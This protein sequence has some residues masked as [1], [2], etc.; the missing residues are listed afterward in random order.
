MARDVADS[1]SKLE[2]EFHRKIQLICLLQ[3]HPIRLKSI[4]D[5]SLGKLVIAVE[6]GS[7]EFGIGGEIAALLGEN[8]RSPKVFVRVAAE[9]FPVASNLDLEDK[10]L[11]SIKKISAA[12]QE[13]IRH[14]RI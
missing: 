7:K 9:G 4:L 14:A 8:H 1:L 11:P 3:L 10:L 13:E 2:E 12:I 5:K 6:E